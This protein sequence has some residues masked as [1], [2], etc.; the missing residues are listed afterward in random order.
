MS[1]ILIFFLFSFAINQAYAQKPIVFTP[2]HPYG[3]VNTEK[4]FTLAYG[5]PAFA[6]FLD[7][8]RPERAFLITQNGSLPLTPIRKEIFDP[9]VN[10]PKIAYSLNINP[11]LI[12]DYLLCVET[13][14]IAE[15]GDIVR[16]HFVKTVLH[17]EKELGWDRL[18]GFDVKIKPYTRPYGLVPGEVF[19]GKG[20]LSG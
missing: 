17:V 1:L 14:N 9:W 19:W 11:N 16:K 12:G 10:K 18:C 5:Q 15:P 6:N 20:P 3:K 13:K 2:D 8:A 4:V 7:F